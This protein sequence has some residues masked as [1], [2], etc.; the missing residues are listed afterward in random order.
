MARRGKRGPLARRCRNL[1][2]TAAAIIGGGT[3]WWLA[4]RLDKEDDS[5]RPV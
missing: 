1:L 5:T 2:A 4:D 3:P